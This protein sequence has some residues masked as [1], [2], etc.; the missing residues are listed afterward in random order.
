MSRAPTID[1]P[2]LHAMPIGSRRLF[3]RAWCFRASDERWDLW[4]PR[5]CSCEVAAYPGQSAAQ[6][7]AI[8]TGVPAAAP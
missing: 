2:Q 7:V 6:V 8:V 3:G 4:D 1:L 5:Q